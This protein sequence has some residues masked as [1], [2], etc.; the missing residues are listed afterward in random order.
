MFMHIYIYIHTYI[1]TSNIYISIYTN[2]QQ[3]IY[4]YIYTCLLTPCRKDAKASFPSPLTGPHSLILTDKGIYP[5]GYM[6]TW[7]KFNETELP[8]K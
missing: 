5:Y 4:I 3:Y 8:S 7:D 2:I 6:N 1:H